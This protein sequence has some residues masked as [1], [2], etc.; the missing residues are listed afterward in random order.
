MKKILLAILFIL[1][2][3]GVFA[4]TPPLNVFQGGT[5]AQ[6]F[7]VG[8]CLKGNGTSPITTGACGG[9]GTGSSTWS[10]TTSTVSGQLINYPNNA[11]DIVNIGSSAT[12]TGKFYFDPNTGTYYLNGTG[13][14]TGPLTSFKF[15][16]AP[17][18]TGTSTIASTFPYAS[19]TAL[20]VSGNAYFP[21][22]G[23][24][25]SLGNVGIGTVSPTTEFH[26]YDNGGHAADLFKIE[27]ASVTGYASAGFFGSAGTQTGSFGYGNGSASTYAGVTFLQGASGVPLALGANGSEKIRITTAGNVGI[28][29]TSPYASLSVV[30]SSGVVADHYTATSSIATSTF[31][32]ID[33]SQS[34]KFGEVQVT[35]FDGTK[36][37]YR[38][39][40]TTD[41]GRGNAVF[42]AV[43]FA[44]A[45]ASSTVEIGA[46]SFALGTRILTN[47]P[48]N[49]AIR[50]Q[51]IDVTNLI[52]TQAN[53]S[54][55]FNFNLVGTVGNMTITMPRHDVNNNIFGVQTPLTGTSTITIDTVKTYADSDTFFPGT[56]ATNGTTFLVYNSQLYCGYDCWASN[57]NTNV[58]DYAYVYN[59][60][61]FSGSPYWP[62]VTGGSRGFNVSGN[63]NVNIYSSTIKIGTGSLNMSIGLQTGSASSTINC[64]NTSIETDAVIGLD[65]VNQQ[66][67][68]NMYG[69][70]FNHN[71]TTGYIDRKEGNF[72]KG[73]F[74][75]GIDLLPPTGVAV[76]DF[77]S[78]S[79][80]TAGQVLRYGIYGVTTIGTTTSY[81][82][83]STSV[84]YTIVTTGDAPI[85]V[86]TDNS[87]ASQ[88]ALICRSINGGA[89]NFYRYNIAQSLNTD[90]GAGWIS[91]TCN[92]NPVAQKSYTYINELDPVTKL[93]Y[94]IKTINPLNVA[95]TTGTSTFAYGINLPSGGCFAINNSCVGGS[96]GSGTVTAVTGTWPIISS[97]GTAPNLTWGGLSTSTAITVGQLPYWTGQNTFGSVATSTPTVTSPITYS[98]T[99]GSFVGGSAGAFA[100]ATCL[101]ANQTV[102]LSGVVTGSGATSITT[103]FGTTNVANSVL[104]NNTSGT[105]I[106]AFLATSSLYTFPWSIAN[107]GTNNTS[108]STG[109]IWFNGTSIVSTS[110]AFTVGN[111]IAT[112]TATS[113]FAGPITV[114][115]S[116][117]AMAGV[118]GAFTGSNNSYVQVAIQNKSI[119]TGASASFVATADNGTDSKFF[120]EMGINNSR[121]VDSTMSA[122]NAGDGFLVSNDGAL[123]IGT[124]SSSNPLA[125]FRVAVGGMAS[126]SLAMV[127]KNPSLNIGFGTSTPYS[128]FTV[129]GNGQDKIVEFVTNA[130]STAL[131]VSD[132][133]FATTTLSGLNISGSATSTSNVGFNLTG[134][135]YAISG[136]CLSTGGS[137]SGTVGSGNAGDLAYYNVSGTSIVGT[138]TRVGYFGS[139]VATSTLATST[140]NGGVVIGGTGAN[141]FIVDNGLVGVNATSSAFMTILGAS[142]QL[143]LCYDASNCFKFSVQSN[144]NIRATPGVNGVS[145]WSFTDTSSAN[146]LD[147]DTTNLRIGIA[148]TTTPWA[149][150]SIQSNN[151]TNPLEAMAT[152][153]GKL[154]KWTDA[155]GNQYTGGDPPTIS[156]CGT[157]AVLF[158]GSNNNAGR[159]Q[160]GSTALQ[161]T[162]TVTFSD[163]GWLGTANAPSCDANIEGGLTIF[164]AASTTRTTMVITSAAT[165]TSDFVNYQCKGF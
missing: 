66:G 147:I 104:A 63:W 36:Y 75:S 20:T 145:T 152:T 12:T 25:N 139:L 35:L 148:G 31:P 15:F 76:T 129:W 49:I 86:W 55:L 158:A 106:P 8:Q 89:Y 52:S 62:G 61:F 88:G 39:T 6:T 60:Q 97:G 112:T 125:E 56:S 79:S 92:P 13:T 84:A 142:E 29:T 107:G 118:L 127:I 101:T 9:G 71:K 135:C 100:C 164:T 16:T 69:C 45:Y 57:N 153:T 155:I 59:T 117:L 146:A 3:V 28:G 156:S 121:F 51:G 132:T 128:D 113:T 93:I 14:S 19:T 24:W 48:N 95:S 65:A 27:Q 2:P 41:I 26:L 82:A 138:S 64:Y 21:G 103:A 110:S 87:F 162:C 37:M 18:F 124:A 161:T 91:G 5:G 72:S 136:A 47:L 143:R 114:G 98:G 42:D 150:L 34:V 11:T 1:L 32:N 4:A 154:L 116:T 94:G 96:G 140:F 44:S 157:G 120:T 160:V 58:I 70:T 108:F 119:G 78:G 68:I 77:G 23:I 123:V 85:L 109:N 122:Q 134:G 83:A 149:S 80:Y 133:G 67:T 43:K 17:Y 53:S 144:G 81:S 50:G 102:T 105:A 163:G 10:T 137:G 111:L 131:S 165:F 30:G 33:I 99:L 22:T 40:T 141:V 73:I 46:G 74:E 126:S 54:S 90:T 7:P 115:S 38:A 130:S 151:S 159:L